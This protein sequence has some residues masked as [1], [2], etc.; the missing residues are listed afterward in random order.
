MEQENRDVLLCPVCGCD[1]CVLPPGVPDLDSA[2]EDTVLFCGVCG[3]EFTKAE[4]R[5]AGW[6][7]AAPEGLSAVEQAVLR[8]LEAQMQDLFE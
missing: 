5:Q 2:G 7:A 4:L 1:Q 3:A 8:A 6:T